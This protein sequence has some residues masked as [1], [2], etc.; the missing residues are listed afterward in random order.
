[1]A[2]YTSIRERQKKVSTNRGGQGKTSGDNKKQ[3]VQGRGD[4]KRKRNLERR[5]R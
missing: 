1:M 3:Q 4:L 2:R 5:R